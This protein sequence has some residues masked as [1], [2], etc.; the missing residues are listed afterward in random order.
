MWTEAV[1][2]YWNHN[3]A[4]HPW[5]VGLAAKHRGDVLDVGCGDGLLAQ[6]LAPVSRSVTGIEPDSETTDRARG[7][8]GDL[9]NV[10][11]SRAS[12]E[13]F[14]P[15]TRRFDL[16]TFVASLHHMDLR[17]TLAR[18][19]DLLT[20][21]GEIAVVGLSANESAWDWVWS[22]CCVPVAAVGDRLHGD[23]PD[24]G[25]TLADPRES[26]RT[27]RRV[28]AE[29]LPGAVIRRK[30]YYRYLLRWSSG[31]SGR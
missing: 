11:I 6:R 24:I 28:T 15:G 14:D 7:R 25:V 19:R 17:T 10:Q 27:I 18:A 1:G 23:T 20:P 21:S 22:A 13:E 5:L 12:F 8:I 4:Y 30:L 3:T 16:I 26:L 2:D 29:V 31:P 9:E